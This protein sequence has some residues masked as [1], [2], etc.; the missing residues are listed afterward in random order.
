MCLTQAAPLGTAVARA[1]Q[2]H[3]ALFFSFT[4][5]VLY[6]GQDGIAGTGPALVSRPAAP[7]R[8]ISAYRRQKRDGRTWTAHTTTRKPMLLLRL[9]GLFLL[10][11][12]AAALSFVLFHEPPRK[13]KPGRLTR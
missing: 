11:A 1:D 6:L 8:C 10:R 4:S 5:A 13:T 7:A 9:F 3:P 2:T 12:A